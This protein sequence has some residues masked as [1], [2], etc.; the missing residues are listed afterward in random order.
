MK[1]RIGIILCILTLA[2]CGLVLYLNRDPA[3]SAVLDSGITID[4]V[5]SV[6]RESLYRLGKVWGFVKY[7][8]PDIIAGELD[9][10]AAL[11]QVL[12]D[13]LQAENAQAANAVLGQW[14]QQ[15]PFSV[16]TDDTAAAC[17]QLQQERGAAEADLDWI[18]D[19]DALGET[20]C[21]YLEDL[22]RTYIGDRPDGYAAFS[23]ETP[24]V[25]FSGEAAYLFDWS[26]AG[27][28]LLA[29]FRFWNAYAYYSPHVDIT[30]TDWD[31]A[32]YEGIDEMLA[33]QTERAYLEALGS[34]ASKTGDAHVSILDANRYLYR[35]YGFRFLPCSFLVLDGQITVQYVPEDE[36]VLR[37]GD[38]LTEVDGLTMAQRV[39]ELSAHFAVPEPDKFAKT[40]SIPLMSA[41]GATAQVT[42]VRDGQT[43]SLTVDTRQQPFQPENPLSNGLIEDGKIGYIDPS[44]LEEGDLEQLMAS[45]A[46]TDGIIV[47]LRQY[48]SVFLPYLLGAY[49]TP[50]PTQFAMMT[51]PN[52]ALPGSFYRMDNFYTGA[53]GSGPAAYT[54]RV[55]LLMNEY[56]LSQSEFTIMALRQSPQAVVIGSPS[57]GADGNAVSISLPGGV[58]AYFTGMGVF[59]P[60]GGQ[61]QRVGLTPDIPCEPTVEGL[62]DGRDELMETAIAHILQ[63]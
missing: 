42:V 13:L 30:P 33:A 5:S 51:L 9:W 31:Q 44:A 54:G 26:D 16:Q 37:P 32:L 43:L 58:Q 29:L 27:V 1:R 22:S 55:V 11:L 15:Y 12:P 39:A 23:A 2:A 35:Y 62:R 49:I 34:L 50:Q 38:I 14:L 60:E 45:F 3:G 61:T 53:D 24:G 63:S 36:T 19:R 21:A 57:A 46:E 7:R 47:D 20:V 6:Q 52:P 17:L 59:T 18:S 41:A 28:K 40:L 8:H 4:S 10:D 56:S 25:D 48:P